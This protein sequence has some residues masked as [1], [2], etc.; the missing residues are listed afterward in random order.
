MSK[1]NFDEAVQALVNSLKD[2][3]PK[4]EDIEKES[5]EVL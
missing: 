4:G 5:P 1:M 3:V 2:S